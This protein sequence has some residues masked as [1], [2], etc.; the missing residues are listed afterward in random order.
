M[1]FRGFHLVLSLLLWI[2]IPA[3]CHGQDELDMAGIFEMEDEFGWGG[4]S[5]YRWGAVTNYSP[6]YHSYNYG[7]IYVAPG[8]VPEGYW[9]YNRR[10]GWFYSSVSQFPMV[11]LSREKSWILLAVNESGTISYYSFETRNWIYKPHRLGERKPKFFDLV[12]EE[13][14]GLKYLFVNCRDCGLVNQWFHGIEVGP[15]YLYEYQSSLDQAINLVWHYRADGW[16]Y[17][18]KTYYP[19][20]G[21]V[22]HYTYPQRK[23]VVLEENGTHFTIISEDLMFG[24]DPTSQSYRIYKP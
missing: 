6:W 18:Q 23:R 21:V 13:L 1:G 16:F 24:Q 5:W 9:M 20:E 7:W 22:F 8:S 17:P 12:P 15:Y 4:F 10:L 11:Y 19:I 14:R 2:S 3:P